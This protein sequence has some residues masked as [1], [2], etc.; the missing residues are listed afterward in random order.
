MILQIHIVASA[1]QLVVAPVLYRHH[2]VAAGY[3]H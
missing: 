3:Y 2:V 1:V